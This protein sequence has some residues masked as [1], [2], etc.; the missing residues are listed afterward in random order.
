MQI[1]QESPYLLDLDTISVESLALIPPE[2][3]SSITTS[4][5]LSV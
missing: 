2:S 3:T 4:N 5:L 1:K